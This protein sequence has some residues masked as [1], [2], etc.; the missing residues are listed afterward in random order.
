[1]IRAFIAI[2]VPESILR[3]CREISDDLR[4]FNLE[5]RFTPTRSIHLTLQFLGNIEKEQIPPIEKI[6]QETG[7]E[8]MSFSLEVGKLGVFPNP[9]R[10]RVVWIGVHPIDILKDLQRNLQERL[11]PLGFPGEERPFHPHLTLVRLKSRKNVSHLIEYVEGEGTGEEA[12]VLEVKEVH[13]YQ[14]ILKPVEL[15]TASW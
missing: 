8:S 11:E 3:R 1:M 7:R 2:A 15:N 4:E 14:S 5:G 9:S 6:L 13:L 12:G 10:P